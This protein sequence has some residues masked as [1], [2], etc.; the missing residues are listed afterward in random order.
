MASH[1]R[2]PPP[3]NHGDDTGTSPAWTSL[4][5]HIQTSHVPLPIQQ[6]HVGARC[7]LQ[8]KPLTVPSSEQD[9]SSL[10]EGLAKT[11]RCHSWLLFLS[12]PTC[13]PPRNP[14]VSP[15]TSRQTLTTSITP[16]AT[17]LGHAPIMSHL[18]PCSLPLRP[19][20]HSP[21]A[22]IPWPFNCTS[23]WPHNP[24]PRD[25]PRGH[26][27]GTAQGY[28]PGKWEPSECPLQG[29][30]AINHDFLKTVSGIYVS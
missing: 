14:A 7:H 13:K 18:L 22:P 16:A 25:L 6:P 2:C 29:M 23:L 21:G 20:G 9:S 15:C 3:H 30:G 12:R 11:R 24:T 1:D 19:S 17:S 4:R 8:T 5:P 28:S 26:H 27:T 10:P